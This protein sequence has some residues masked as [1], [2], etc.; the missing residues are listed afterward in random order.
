M[1]ESL[2]EDGLDNQIVQLLTLQEVEAIIWLN[3]FRHFQLSLKKVADI[4]SKRFGNALNGIYRN[5]L[6]PAFNIADI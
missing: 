4:Y 2:A 1:E 3:E 5:V 6:P